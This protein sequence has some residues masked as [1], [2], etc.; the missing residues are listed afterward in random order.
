M[1]LELGAPSLTLLMLAG[2]SRAIT[3]PANLL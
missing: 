1:D 3:A 2:S